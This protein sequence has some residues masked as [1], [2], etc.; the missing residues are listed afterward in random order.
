[1]ADDIGGR[2]DRTSLPGVLP[3]SHL[4]ASLP[5]GGRDVPPAAEG[6][7]ERVK[8]RALELDRA[9]ELGIAVGGRA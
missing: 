1:M 3:W 5:G 2:P 9:R 7:D 6:A 4:P 8:G